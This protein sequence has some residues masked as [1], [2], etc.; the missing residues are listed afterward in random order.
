MSLSKHPVTVA[1]LPHKVGP[2]TVSWR[3]L[4]ASTKDSDIIFERR[5]RWQVEKLAVK[6]RNALKL[7]RPEGDAH[8]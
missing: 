7:L 1:I 5:Y 8:G 2:R 3:L 6:L 4:I